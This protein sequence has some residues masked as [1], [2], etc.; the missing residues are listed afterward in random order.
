MSYV[1]GCAF[2]DGLEICVVV[3]WNK[4]IF[5]R[6]LLKDSIEFSLET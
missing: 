6:S 1:T 3:F 2:L 5:L 4:R